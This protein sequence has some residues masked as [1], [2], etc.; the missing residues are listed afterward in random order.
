MELGILLAIQNSKWELIKQSKW[1]PP[2]TY[3]KSIFY[4]WIAITFLFYNQI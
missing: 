3:Y 1:R 2:L 4:F